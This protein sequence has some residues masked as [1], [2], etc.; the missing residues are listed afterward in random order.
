MILGGEE[1]EFVT[2][3]DV[4]KDRFWVL[5]VALLKI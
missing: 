5:A 4:A 3:S 1:A 2:L